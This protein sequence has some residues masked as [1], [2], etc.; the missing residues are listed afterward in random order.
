[1]KLCSGQRDVEF[2]ADSL[3][4][5]K[6]VVI[7]SAVVNEKRRLE[8]VINGE[9]CMLKTLVYYTAFYFMANE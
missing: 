3:L 2:Y 5:H 6:N 1:M 4:P 7:Q 9:V 8:V